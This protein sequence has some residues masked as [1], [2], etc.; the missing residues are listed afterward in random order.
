MQA[1]P[2]NTTT[3]NVCG[4]ITKSSKEGYYD[5][6]RLHSALGNRPPDEFELKAACRAENR[7]VTIKAFVNKENV[8]K[9]AKEPLGTGT[10]TPP[11]P[12]VALWL[13]NCCF[14]SV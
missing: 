7:G 9:I 12:F 13:A 2:P 5:C 8:E 3:W 14:A 10:Q 4:P 6:Q 1:V 11:S